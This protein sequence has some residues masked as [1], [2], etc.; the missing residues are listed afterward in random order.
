M[1][2]NNTPRHVRIQRRLDKLRAK[3]YSLAPVPYGGGNPYYKCASCDRSMIEASYK[4]HYKGCQYTGLENQISWWEGQLKG[5]L[6]EQKSK[7]T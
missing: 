4:G 7:D 2:D 3:L 6:D 1:R 5:A